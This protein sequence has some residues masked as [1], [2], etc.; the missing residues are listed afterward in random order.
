MIVK[1]ALIRE[2]TTVEMMVRAIADHIV[3]GDLRPGAKLDEMTLAERFAVSRTPIREALGQLAAMGLVDRRPNRGAIVAL[4]TQVQLASMFESMAELEGICGRF[5]ALRMSSVERAELE[6]GH[7]ASARLVY[8]GKEEDYE[9]YNTEFHSQLYRG[10]HNDHIF[11]LVSLTRSRLAP[12]RRAQ[13]RLVGR[14][15]KSWEEHDE[16]VTA[17]LRG[18]ANAAAEAARSHVSKVSSASSVFASGN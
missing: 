9:A 1:K 2:G 11:E 13:F 4:V 3:S 17:I 6:R 18:D 15:A 16:I 5:S 10:A 14:L 7:Q 12:F 8:N